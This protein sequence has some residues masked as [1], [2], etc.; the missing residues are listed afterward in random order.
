VFVFI[1]RRTFKFVF[2]CRCFIISTYCPIL[3]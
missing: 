3:R 2:T 1:P